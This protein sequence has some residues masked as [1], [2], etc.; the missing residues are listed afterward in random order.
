M[1]EGRAGR[2]EAFRDLRSLQGCCQWT[3]CEPPSGSPGIPGGAWEIQLSLSPSQPRGGGPPRLQKMTW[4]RK[5]TN[6]TYLLLFPSRRHPRPPCLSVS[7]SIHLSPTQ[8]HLPSSHSLSFLC[9]V[10]APHFSCHSRPLFCPLHSLPIACLQPGQP[11]APRGCR[12]HSHH[13]PPHQHQ[14][15]TSVPQP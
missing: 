9:L 3:A 5:K 2:G 1:G 15:G 12:P 10:T 13:P 11:L 14:V 8:P 4:V 6:T 7:F